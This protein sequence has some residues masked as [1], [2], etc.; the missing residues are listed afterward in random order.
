MKYR[1]KKHRQNTDMEVP[2]IEQCESLEAKRSVIKVMASN[3]HTVVE[4]IEKKRKLQEQA[5]RIEA[6][7][8]S[9]I[10]EDE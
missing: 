9:E 7:S 3:F 6:V 1:I 5:S 8:S 4:Q 2:K 10:T